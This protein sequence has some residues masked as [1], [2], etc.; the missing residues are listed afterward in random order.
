VRHA[1]ALLGTF[2]ILAG[3]VALFN[4]TYSVTPSQ[5]LVVSV[6]YDS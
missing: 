4:E 3:L 2:H 1:R 5:D 6:S